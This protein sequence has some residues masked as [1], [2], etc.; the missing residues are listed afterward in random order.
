MAHIRD[1]ARTH[2]KS[3]PIDARLH[4]CR[5]AMA[6]AARQAPR[7]SSFTAMN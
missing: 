4:V 1:S 3:D 5:L 7:T 6:A 2:G